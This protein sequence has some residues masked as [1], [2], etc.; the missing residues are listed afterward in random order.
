MQL[1]ALEIAQ[2]IREKVADLNEE[3]VLAASLEVDVEFEVLRVPDRVERTATQ[4][5]VWCSQEVR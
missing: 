5:R 3:L 4:L 2:R 1:A